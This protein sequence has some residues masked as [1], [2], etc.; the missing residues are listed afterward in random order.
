[1]LR[2]N[3][4][5]YG[6]LAICLHWIMALMVFFI[7]GLGLYMVELS[8]YDAWYKGS[9]ELHKSLGV[10]AAI[11]LFIRL[12]WRSVN[13]SP[14]ALSNKEWER[15]ASHLTH[16]ALYLGLI[17]LVFTGYFISTAKGHGINVFDLVTVPA[18]PWHIAQQED[19]AGEIHEILA[20][21][22]VVMAAVHAMAA[23]KHH[24]IN[25]NDVLS[26]MIKPKV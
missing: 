19:I 15:K 24:F 10:V 13:Q 23:L 20:W 7:F 21:I 6:W 14:E 16:I 9:L 22:I 26:R 11:L 25:K 3:T 17:F 4:Q 8:Y 1:M 12:I 5:T 18:L 2:N